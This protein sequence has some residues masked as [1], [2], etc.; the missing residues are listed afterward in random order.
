MSKAYLTHVEL[1]REAIEKL[2][3]ATPNQ[4]MAFISRVHPEIPVKKSSFRADII[5][6]SVNHTSSHHYPGMPKFLFYEKSSRLYRLHDPVKDGRWVVDSRGARRVEQTEREGKP[7]TIEPSM[8][9]ATISLEADLRTFI[10]ERLDT[11]EEGL[12]PYEGT[13]SVEYSVKS[14]RIDI[15]AKDKCGDPVVIE[16]KAGTASEAT[17]TQILAYMADMTPEVDP[18][19]RVRGI[20]VAYHFAERL[21]TA[22]S[23]LPNLELVRYKVNFQFERKR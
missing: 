1:I 19:H 23:I 17:L 18:M 14:G 12:I 8:D 13:N 20:I 22:A 16:L 21:I 9:E 2:G 15:L 5:G 7:I 6:C 4:I 10:F 3:K 11:L